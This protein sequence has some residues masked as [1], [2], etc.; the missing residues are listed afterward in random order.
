MSY[1]SDV[2]FVL[3]YVSVSQSFFSQQNHGIVVPCRACR[4][5]WDLSRFVLL[6]FGL[7]CSNDCDI[8]VK[9]GAPG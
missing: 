1:F 9:F 4:K 8:Q 6:F 3:F 2:T 5:K 7:E